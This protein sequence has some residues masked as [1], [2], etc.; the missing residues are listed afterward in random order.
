M[1]F[2]QNL[3]VLEFE[4]SN[5]C[6]SFNFWAR[7]MKFWILKVLK[8]YPKHSF[9]K[10]F[11]LLTEKLS[12]LAYRVERSSHDESH[13]TAMRTQIWLWNLDVVKKHGQMLFYRPFPG[14]TFLIYCIYSLK[15]WFFSLF[16]PRAS[17]MLFI[18]NK[19]FSVTAEAVLR[20]FGSK[21]RHFWPFGTFFGLYRTQIGAKTS[22][23]RQ[24]EV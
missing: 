15:R 10:N 19:W 5:G 1:P 23:L 7:I 11:D 3:N 18:Q 4:P 2:S 24:F 20:T 9:I 6:S 21:I 22:I 16:Q 12:Y 17:E 14:D 8:S 13:I